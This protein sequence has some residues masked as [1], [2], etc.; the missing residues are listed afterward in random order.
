VLLDTTGTEGGSGG[1][2]L[3]IGQMSKAPPRSVQ[4]LEGVNG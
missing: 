4:V 1:E 3:Q 2:M